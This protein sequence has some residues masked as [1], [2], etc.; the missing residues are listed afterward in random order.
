[1]CNRFTFLKAGGLFLAMGAVVMFMPEP[2]SACGFKTL[3]VNASMSYTNS[4]KANVVGEVAVYGHTRI[5]RRLQLALRAAGHNIRWVANLDEARKADVVL[6]STG[7]LQ[8]LED[9]LKDA[10]AKIVVVMAAGEETTRKLEYAVRFGDRTTTQIAM[11]EQV[12]R[13]ARGGV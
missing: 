9:G 4:H 1:M 8:Q 12:I 3:G 2:A 13:S 5:K 10:N 7:S 11:V 6:T